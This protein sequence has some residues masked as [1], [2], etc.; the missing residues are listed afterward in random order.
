MIILISDV[1]RYVS[2]I[3]IAD[4]NY[5]NKYSAEL[6]YSM[7]LNKLINL[8]FISARNKEKGKTYEETTGLSIIWLNKTT[9]KIGDDGCYKM[10]IKQ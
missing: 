3:I 6:R 2:T 7:L 4:L 8:D 5:P 10:L 1:S 9:S